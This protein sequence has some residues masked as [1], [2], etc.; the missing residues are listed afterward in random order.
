M[1]FHH[2][3][4]GRTAA[5]TLFRTLP[6]VTAFA[7]GACAKDDARVPITRAPLVAGCDC[8]ASSW[9]FVD[10]GT[11][12]GR[13]LTSGQSLCVDAGTYTG[14]LTIGSNALV[15]VDTDAALRVPTIN[16]GGKLLVF[17]TAGSEASPVGLTFSAGASIDNFGV[18]QLGSVNFNGAAVITNYRGAEL[19]FRS[20]FALRSQGSGLVNYGVFRA[21]SNFDSAAGTTFENNGYGFISGELAF[22]GESDN[23]G[24]LEITTRVNVNPTATFRN[25]CTLLSRGPYNVNGNYANDG[26]AFVYADTG[27][28]EFNVTSAGTVT[29]GALGQVIVTSSDPST[30]LANLRVDGKLAGEGSYYVEDNTVCQ[31]SGSAIGTPEAPIHF[32]D[33]SPPQV[34]QLFD[35]Q[36]GTV[37]HVI[38]PARPTLPT[39]AEVRLGR[40]GSDCRTIETCTNDAE[41]GQIDSGCDSDLPVCIAVDDVNVCVECIEDLD[42]AGGYTCNTAA[43]R[44]QAGPE[45]FAND[46]NITTAEGQNVSF[47]ASQLASNDLRVNP[48]TVRLPGGVASLMTTNG[49][50]TL[51]NGTLTYTPKANPGT[52]DSF[53]YEV[54]GNG[55]HVDLCVE[56]T[57]AVT[58]N[59]APDL[60]PQSRLVAVGT[61]SVAFDLVPAYSDPDQHALA[62]AS[63]QNLGSDGGSATFVNG[64]MTYTPSAPNVPGARV[65]S[66]GFCDTGTPSACGVGTVTIIFNDPPVLQGAS[67]ALPRGGVGDVPVAS[68]VTSLGVV[69]GDDPGDGDSNG[70][71]NVTVLSGP[72][73]LNGSNLRATAPGTLGA[74]SCSVQICEELPPGSPAVCATTTVTIDVVNR[75]PEAVDDSALVSEDA[76]VLINVLGNDSDPDGDALSVGTLGT[77][78]HG[79]VV[80]LAGKVRYTP[81]PNYSGTDSFTYQAC[82]SFNACTSATVNVVVAPDNDPPVA[83]DDTAT[84]PYETAVVID[85]LKNDSDSDGD[86]LAI[87]T[88]ADPPHGTVVIA[89]G[90]VTYT[91]DA[92][93]EGA[94]SFV[95]FVR[96]P[97]GATATATVRVT[98][99]PRN[100]QPPDANDD[101]ATV[102]EDG[103]VSIPVLTNDTDP[104]NAPLVI[105]SVNNPPHGTATVASGEIVYVPDPGYEGPDTFTYQACDPENA[106]ATATVT[107][108]VTHVNHPP[109]A[110]ADDATTPEGSPVAIDVLAND[111]DPDDDDLSIASVTDPAHGTATVVN[112]KVSYTPD[113][114]FAGTETFSYTITDPTGATATAQITVVVVPLPNRGPDA[115]DDTVSVAAGDEVRIP[116]LANDTD[117]DGDVL[118]IGE[119]S[120]PTHGTVTVAGSDIVYLPDPGY[121][122]TDIFT[123]A[124][125]DPE[126][127]CATATVTVTVTPVA[128]PNAPPVA[129][130]DTD[131]TTA[132]HDITVLVL[133]NDSD[134]DGDPLTLVSVTDPA[135]GT[136]TI[137]DG[138][139]V[140]TPDP[141]YVGQDTFTYLVR[142]PDGATDTATV[143]VIVT[144]DDDFPPNVVPD[145]TTVDED[146]SVSIPVLDNDSDPDGD[147]LT[148]VVV[149]D[150]AHGTT[151]IVDGEVV[152]TPDPDYNGQDTFTYTACNPANQ[153][154]TTT[155]T[156]T[157]VPVNDTPIAVDDMATTDEEV[158]VVSDVLAN[159][160][161][162]DGDPL[163]IVSV[164]D[165]EHGTAT[166]E[167]GA[168]VF[169][170]DVDFSGTTTF[171]Y[172]VQDPSGATSTATVT[173]TVVSDR[174]DDDDG[175]SDEDELTRGT[176]KDDQDTDDDGILDGDEVTGGTDPLNSDTDGDGILDGTEIGMTEP[177]SDDTDPNV[178]VPDLDPNTTTDPLDPDT[179]RGGVSDGVE[180]ANHNGRVDPG[181]P[182]P[183]IT[184]D[185]FPETPLDL[186]GLT[187]QG[188]GGC[189]GGDASAWALFGGLAFAL[190]SRRTIRR[191]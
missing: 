35:T 58:I 167:D 130:D 172:T 109:I 7:V 24:L 155:V 118:V 93:Y 87:Q 164:T 69:N 160:T 40:I 19:N 171:S 125:C 21:L 110:I 134:P 11:N 57:V 18:T 55:P 191:V 27:N 67:L 176:D 116:V 38:R 97:S 168:I 185:D 154:G 121:V 189:A 68:L 28:I 173:V 102:P 71:G 89:N 107:I 149:S 120:D 180:D 132:N 90:K 23:R 60:A 178:F 124:A 151:T 82:D 186:S 145:T 98:V 76:S 74:S 53:D 39:L 165:P 143:T 140:Y 33:A 159:D 44:C 49:T 30:R 96:D 79:T 36:T 66:V 163:T 146:G 113:P 181:E 50:V 141:D 123:Y 106:C 101:S 6:L 16:S 100:N 136:A 142:D 46:D 187:A 148:L 112:G 111:S 43:R 31:G 147:P 72:C 184:D 183:N 75:P 150:P 105:A 73:V 51:V 188:S 26:L 153:C 131:Q 8:D 94:D 179:D 70:I 152:Y 137:V 126:G 12:T 45:P 85:V 13:T 108:T 135:H 80:V 22:E 65:V 170:P 117:P 104:E 88:V 17:G 92:G 1:G 15:C 83:L 169:V 128:P 133:A 48:S 47:P 42:C 177:I 95:Y 77:P 91:P 10:A 9:T 41:P 59:R 119:V 32:Y 166:I 20:S 161:D 63:F 114:G 86:V 129:V 5:A 84:T 54:C 34:P 174:D 29:Q 156:V 158:A 139:V 64:V 25:T 138:S 62:V 162:P 144:P 127:L 52:S 81:T 99:N 122:G 157:V 182:D 190:V 4:R 56:A 103:R 2:A 3:S 61:T 78:G 175:L 14:S 115:N 37:A